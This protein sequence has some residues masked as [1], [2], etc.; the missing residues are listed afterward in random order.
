MARLGQFWLADGVWQGAALL[1][2]GWSANVIN[3]ALPTG[4]GMKYKRGFWIDAQRGTYS[5][6][7]RHGQSIAI[8][9][10]RNMIIVLT[11]KFPDTDRMPDVVGLIHDAVTAD[12]ALPDSVQS[13]NELK[14]TVSAVGGLRWCPIPVKRVKTG[15]T[16]S[17][18][19]KVIPCNSVS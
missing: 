14:A 10:A 4:T 18:G 5:A 3:E 7:G 2:S 19:W 16:S 9:P 11:G 15:I 13:Q 1:P 12:Q 8:D 6:M 17:G